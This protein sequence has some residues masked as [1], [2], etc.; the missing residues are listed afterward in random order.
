MSDF[1]STRPIFNRNI[2][3]FLH[4]ICSNLIVISS[5]ELRIELKR[6]RPVA[7][8][9][10]RAAII[11]IFKLLAFKYLQIFLYSVHLYSMSCEIISFYVYL[12]IWFS[13]LCINYEYSYIRYCPIDNVLKQL[14]NIR[15]F[16]IKFLREFYPEVG[17]WTRLG[18]QCPF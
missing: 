8:L 4:S 16:N 2:I 15:V 6:V 3:E 1:D 5:F 12:V 10:R 17:F 7:C 18:S 13:I 11:F 14:M 9:P